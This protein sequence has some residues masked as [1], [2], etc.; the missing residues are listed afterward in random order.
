[1]GVVWFLFLVMEGLCFEFSS[2]TSLP[3]DLC[4]KLLTSLI[5]VVKYIKLLRDETKGN[6]NPPSVST[7]GISYTKAQTR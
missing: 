5:T 1:M 2:P 3:G 7:V 6:G 4:L